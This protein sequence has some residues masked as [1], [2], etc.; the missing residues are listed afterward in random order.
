MEQFHAYENKGT[1][2]EIYPYLINLQHPLANILKHVL[3]A[4]LVKLDD[5]GHPPPA[6]IC[7]IVDIA[8]EPYIA[9]T[10]MM[11]GIDNKELGEPVANLT[12]QRYLLSGAVDFLMNGY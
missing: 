10:H 1:G 12:A 6:K 3:V 8:G 4:P 7:P 11:A 5:L 9:M 2:H